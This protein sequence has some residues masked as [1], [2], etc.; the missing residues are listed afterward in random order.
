MLSNF[1]LMK[2]SDLLILDPN[3]SARVDALAT[4]ADQEMASAETLRLEAETK[5]KNA[6][7]R[8]AEAKRKTDA[9]ATF[10]AALGEKKGV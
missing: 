5:M 9:V 7:A 3:F 1:G 10:R 6:D 8:K 2:I 4:Q